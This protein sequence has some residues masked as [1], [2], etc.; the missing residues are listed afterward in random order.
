[1]PKSSHHFKIVKRYKI[2]RKAPGTLRLWTL[3]PLTIWHELQRHEQLCVDPALV[4]Q[5]FLSCYR[6]M[7]Q[8]M[9]RRLPHDTGHYPW[10]AYPGEKPDLRSWYGWFSERQAVRIELQLASHKVLISDYEAWHCVLNSWPLP[11]S[12]NA[13]AEDEELTPSGVHLLDC[14][15][16]TPRQCKVIESWEHIFDLQLL[17]ANGWAANSLQACFEELRLKDVVAVEVLKVR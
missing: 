9:A 12:P 15:S 10:W 8:Q 13:D 7:K 3:Q 16:P 5:E 6:W 17:A 1:M 11:L 14:P 2:A 4:E